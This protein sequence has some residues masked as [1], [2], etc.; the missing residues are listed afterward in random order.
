MM[1][2][3]IVL[4]SDSDWPVMEPGYSVLKEFDVPTV[5]LVASAHRT[6]EAVREFALSAKEKG[7]G[8][9]IG[10]AGAAAHLPG[11]IASY[12]ML[13]VIGVP[14]SGGAL[15]GM[16]ALLSIIQMPSGVPVGTMAIDGGK[17]AALYAISILALSN[18]TLAKRLLLYRSDQAEGVRKKN[19]AL[20]EK[21]EQEA[22]Q[23]RK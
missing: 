20:R 8:V 16:D 2:V 9:I 7:M 19:K 6:P 12:T 13:P 11:V 17:N 4:G 10:V 15:K 3:G 21:L 14:V 23:R 22:E 18:E 5:I 1:K